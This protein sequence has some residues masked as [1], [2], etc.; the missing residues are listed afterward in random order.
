MKYYK[1]NSD[2]HLWVV[3]NPVDE[4]YVMAFQL[5]HYSHCKFYMSWYHYLMVLAGFYYVKLKTMNN[6]TMISQSMLNEQYLEIKTNVDYMEI[7]TW[8][9]MDKWNKQ[10]VKEREK[11]WKAF[12]GPREP[13]K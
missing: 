13:V 2:A 10:Q 1:G 5:K 9:K 11:Y 8:L 7:D 6:L 3:V 12:I 4:I